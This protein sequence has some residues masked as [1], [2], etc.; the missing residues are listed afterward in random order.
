[1]GSLFS[2]ILLTGDTEAVEEEYM[3]ACLYSGSLTVI[4]GPD[5]AITRCVHSASRRSWCPWFPY[6]VSTHISGCPP[7]F[8]HSMNVSGNSHS[9]HDERGV[10]AH[11]EVVPMDVCG[12]LDAPVEQ[13]YPATL[14]TSG[15]RSVSLA[16]LALST[17]T[18]TARAA[19]VVSRPTVMFPVNPSTT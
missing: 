18:A 15:S 5:E 4:R 3:S 2:R 13:R 7:P 11:V 12:D 8:V 19:S 9:T 16:Y 6:Y 17:K 10:P 1:V 14:S